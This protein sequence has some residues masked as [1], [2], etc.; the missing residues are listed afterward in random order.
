V[1]ERVRKNGQKQRASGNGCARHRTTRHDTY[2]GVVSDGS[3]RQTVFRV[4]IL[5]DHFLDSAHGTS[6]KGA[7]SAK[8][9]ERERWKE[10]S[11]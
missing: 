2:L 10:T 5:G 9:C 1:S 8:V 7:S 11:G 3:I 6:G 4:T